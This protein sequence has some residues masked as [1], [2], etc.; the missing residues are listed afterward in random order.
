[1][2]ELQNDSLCESRYLQDKNSAFKEVNYSFSNKLSVM[3]INSFN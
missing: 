3:N 1:M 2:E